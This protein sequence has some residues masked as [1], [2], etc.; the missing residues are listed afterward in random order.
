MGVLDTMSAAAP[1]RRSVTLILD[2]SLQ[3]QVDDLDER[4][5]A[6]IDHDS[7]HGTSEDPAPQFNAVILEREKILEQIAASQVTFVFESMDWTERILLQS[8]HPARDGNLVDL[9]RGYNF[10]TF[11]PALVRRSCVEVTGHDGDTKTAAEIPADL[12]ERLLGIPG[13]DAIS[14]ENAADGVAV[15]AR[16]AVRGTL[17]VTQVNRLIQAADDAN[18][19]DPTVPPSALSLLVSQDS[20]ESSEQPS[21]GTS[22]RGDG[23]DGNRPTSQTSSG[24]RKR[25]SKKAAAKKPSSGKSAGS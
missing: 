8:K 13:A 15:P 16:E 3:A 12:W 6:A 23:A 18:E 2:S 9:A 7:V 10:S 20:G 24:G 17:N 19:Q 4:M 1:V 25:T 21:P 14:A 11:L 5:T 22:P